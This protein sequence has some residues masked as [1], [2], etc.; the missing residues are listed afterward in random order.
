LIRDTRLVTV[1]IGAAGPVPRPP[2]PWDLVEHYANL[3]LPYAA[4][5]LVSVLIAFWVWFVWLR[6]QYRRVSRV[7]RVGRDYMDRTP[8]ARI[9]YAAFVTVIAIVFQMAWLFLT[10]WFVMA[11]TWTLHIE[12]ETHTLRWNNWT[13]TYLLVCTVILAI[14]YGITLAHRDGESI[15]LAGVSWLPLVVPALATAIYLLIF[16]LF[17]VLGLLGLL[18]GLLTGSAPPIGETLVVTGI[19]VVAHLIY[20]GL[21]WAAAAAPI[22][23][24]RLWR[25][26][27]ARAPWPDDLRTYDRTHRGFRLG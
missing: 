19:I 22:L 13:A 2:D 3:L 24:A 6:E 11:V 18:L 23:V 4:A 10:W 16:L 14:S 9:A 15:V 1:S 25:N 12:P 21:C 7:G 27:E 20:L 5:W 8:G 17:A 26:P